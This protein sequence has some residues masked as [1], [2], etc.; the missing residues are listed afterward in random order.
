MT[1]RNVP[2]SKILGANGSQQ[3]PNPCLMPEHHHTQLENIFIRYTKFTNSKN[4]YNFM[5]RNNTCTIV[6][7]LL[8][9]LLYASYIN[10]KRG[11]VI[12]STQ[13]L[14]QELQAASQRIRHTYNQPSQLPTTHYSSIDLS[15]NSM[16]LIHWS[17][18]SYILHAHSARVFRG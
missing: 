5:N 3:L 16:A 12:K 7:Q 2:K 9:L 1:V 17:T 10:I 18:R 6:L 8:L 13:I 15:A 4:E 11:L 14:E